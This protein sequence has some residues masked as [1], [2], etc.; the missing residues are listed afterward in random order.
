M[1]AILITPETQLNMDIYACVKECTQRQVRFICMRKSTGREQ[2]G[3]KK[4]PFLQ[5]QQL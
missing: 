5:L 2:S 1:T 4:E 3:R